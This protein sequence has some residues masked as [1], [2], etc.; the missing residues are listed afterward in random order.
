MIKDKTQKA[1]GNNKIQDSIVQTK[2]NLEDG[3]GGF[4]LRG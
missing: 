4:F 2:Q 1:S 3:L